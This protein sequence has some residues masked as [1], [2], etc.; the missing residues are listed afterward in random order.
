[1]SSFSR[2]FKVSPVTG[3]RDLKYS[4]PHWREEIA[5]LSSSWIVPFIISKDDCKLLFIKDQ[6]AKDAFEIS[7]IIKA[8]WTTMILLCNFTFDF[9]VDLS[10]F[11]FLGCFRQCFYLFNVNYPIQCFIYIE[12]NDSPTYGCGTAWI[13]YDSAAGGRQL[14]F[15]SKYR[16]FLICRSCLINNCTTHVYICLGPNFWRWLV[17]QYCVFLSHYPTFSAVSPSAH[18]GEA[19]KHRLIYELKKETQYSVTN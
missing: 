6:R 13:I 9:C 10:D 18:C 1:M 3:R 17:I 7:G 5:G 11:R 19:M 16:K 14:W 15:L 4:S 2:A 12:F 8:M